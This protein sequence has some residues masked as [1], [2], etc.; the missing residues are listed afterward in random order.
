MSIL[1]VLAN[2]SGFRYPDRARRDLEGWL[3]RE[4]SGPLARA[5]AE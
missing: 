5:V 1:D 3:K 4:V 2:V